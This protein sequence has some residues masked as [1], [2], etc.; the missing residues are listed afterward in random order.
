MEHIEEADDVIL[1]F[2][3][4]SIVEVYEHEDIEL[5]EPVE[6]K[7][8]KDEVIDVTVC[9][10][11]EDNYG[12]QFGDGTVSFIRKDMVEVIAVNP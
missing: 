9:S 8:T 11:N 10:V 1:K 4:D 7:F 3:E 6:E 12:I 5:H 2:K